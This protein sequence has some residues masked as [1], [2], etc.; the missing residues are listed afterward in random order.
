MIS[1]GRKYLH[2]LTNGRW[3]SGWYNVKHM[4]PEFRNQ[5][6]EMRI[7]EMQ[8]RF[9]L[10]KRRAQRP[11]TGVGTGV[12]IQAPN[13]S[14]AKGSDRKCIFKFERPAPLEDLLGFNGF[15]DAW[16]SFKVQSLLQMSLILSQNDVVEIL[17]ASG[18]MALSRGQFYAHGKDPMKDVTKQVIPS[19]LFQTTTNLRFKRCIPS[20][21]TRTTKCISDGSAFNAITKNEQS[22]QHPQ[23]LPK[24][25]L[26]GVFNSTIFVLPTQFL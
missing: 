9:E 24:L 13:C 12:N 3:D 17:Y 11:G 19:S 20:S 8:K 16:Q 4:T 22:I 14:C 6:Y 5:L 18:V 23:S 21:V 2:V 7:A 26:L 15:D 1:P 25:N 10:K